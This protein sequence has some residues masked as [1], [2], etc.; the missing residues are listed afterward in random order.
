MMSS[1][2][3][4]LSLRQLPSVEDCLRPRGLHGRLGMKLTY[5][6]HSAFQIETGEHTLLIDPFISGNPHTEVDPA[7][8]KADYILLTHGHGDH[9]G[10]TEIIARANDA[11]VICNYELAMYVG[12][13]GLTTH[14]MH[15]GGGYDFPF[16][17]AKLMPALHGSALPDENGLPIYLGPAGGFLLCLGNKT[18]YHLGD[19][20]LFGDLRLIASLHSIDIAMVPIG[21]NFTMGPECALKAVEMLTPGVVIPIHYNT[22]PVIQLTDKQLDAFEAG[23]VE[24]GVQPEMLSPGASLEF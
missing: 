16:G 23:V 13:K 24:L 5:F 1:Q 4:A 14:A 19:T 11:T 20:G 18:L 9:Y 7:T 2:I 15:I 8:V 6:G 22:M 3:A 12:T 21:G 17:Y 10:D